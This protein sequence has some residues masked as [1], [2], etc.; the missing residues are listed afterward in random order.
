MLFTDIDFADSCYYDNYTDYK[1]SYILIKAIIAVTL[2]LVFYSIAVLTEQRK[3]AISKRVP[4]FLTTGVA[5][6]ISSSVLMIIGSRKIPITIDG[7][8]SYSV[9]LVMLINTILVW[10]FWLK[11][12]STQVVKSFNVYTWLAYSWWVIAYI[13]GAIIAMTLKIYLSTFCKMVVVAKGERLR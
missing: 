5:F 6:G 10:R 8:I 11:N 4:T 1:Y 2:A 3:Y 9:L 13:A 7:F 12:R